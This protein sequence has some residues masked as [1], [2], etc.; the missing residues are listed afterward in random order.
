MACLFCRIVE[1]NQPAD[2]VHEDDDLIVFKD[3]NPK[4]AVHVLLVPKE[5]IAT[6]NDL[7]DR[8]TALMGKLL[9]TVKQLA[10]QWGIAEQGYRLTMNV[11]RGGGQIIDHLHMHLVSGWKH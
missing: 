2:V 8:H 7:E 10:A 6:V 11:G 4:G 5:H 1:K 3:I 9:L